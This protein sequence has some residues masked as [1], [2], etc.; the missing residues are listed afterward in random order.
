[1]STSAEEA[2]VGQEQHGHHH[3]GN[4]H[5]H[6]VTIHVNNKEVFLQAGNY[7]IATIK[8]LAGVPQADD[9]DQLVDCQLRPLP[10][11]GHAHIHGCE[12]FISHVKDGGSS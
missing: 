6:C 7:A 5:D 8:K 9:L 3:D 2:R 11:D 12:I 1:M 4:G 10:D